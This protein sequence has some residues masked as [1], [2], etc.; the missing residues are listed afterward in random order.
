[1]GGAEFGASLCRRQELPGDGPAGRV[2]DR[3]AERNWRFASRAQGSGRD[4]AWRV[5]GVDR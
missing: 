3:A 2:A 4:Q 1:M 5:P